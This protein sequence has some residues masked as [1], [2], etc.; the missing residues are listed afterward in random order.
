MT[1]NT[2]TKPDFKEMVASV[3]EAASKTEEA[4]AKYTL[5]ISNEDKTTIL[6]NVEGAIKDLAAALAKKNEIKGADIDPSAYEHLPNSLTGVMVHYFVKGLKDEL[7]IAFEEAPTALKVRS[8][9]PMDKKVAGKKRLLTRDQKNELLAKTQMA[10]Y[11]DKIGK[12]EMTIEQAM[13]AV[14][15]AYERKQNFEEMGY[16][17][18]IKKTEYPYWADDAS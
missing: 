4:A 18:P 13:Y 16:I 15:D 1:P 6:L 3:E 9:N 5:P 11:E 17:L 7:D 14:K 12:G 10:F 8:S 2:Q